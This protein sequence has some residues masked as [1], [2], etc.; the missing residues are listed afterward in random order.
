MREREELGE[1]NK[2]KTK[3][4]KGKERE[5]KGRQMDTRREQ[6]DRQNHVLTGMVRGDREGERGRDKRFYC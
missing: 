4:E 1:E 3:R 5:G 6:T 2:G